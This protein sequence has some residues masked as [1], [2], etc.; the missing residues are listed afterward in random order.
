MSSWLCWWHG[1][2]LDKPSP[3]HLSTARPEER[4][5]CAG[6]IPGASLLRWY[7]TASP[8]VRMGCQMAHN[9]YAIRTPRTPSW[10]VHRCRGMTLGPPCLQFVILFHNKPAPSQCLHAPVLCHWEE[11]ATAFQTFLQAE[12]QA[13]TP[14]VP[15]ST[16]NGFRIYFYFFKK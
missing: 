2:L 10:P 8:I 12:E 4:L 7:T 14:Q 13:Q 11:N 5:H 1:I 15:S 3:W 9:L 6:R 16:F